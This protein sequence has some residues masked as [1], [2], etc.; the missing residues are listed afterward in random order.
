VTPI[1]CHNISI[2]P[3]RDGTPRE[4]NTIH[5]CSHENWPPARQDI[6][7]AKRSARFVHYRAWRTLPEWSLY[8]RL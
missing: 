3:L 2:K 1:E 8:C 6:I 4:T 5:K 7:N